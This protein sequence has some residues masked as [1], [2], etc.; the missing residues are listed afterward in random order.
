MSAVR[1]TRD[2]EAG[3]AAPVGAAAALRRVRHNPPAARTNTDYAETFQM[4]RAYSLIVR[5]LENFPERAVLKIDFW[6]Q[7]SRFLYSSETR[8]CIL[9]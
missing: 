3:A 7:L 5:S 8:S 2:A 6:T 4:S 1:R 9:Q